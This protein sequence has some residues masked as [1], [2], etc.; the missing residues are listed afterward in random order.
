MASINK[1]ILIGNL[2][3]DPEL[4]KL[5]SGT[6][7]CTF[8]VA[9]N[10]TWKDKD[11]NKQE[12][13]EFHNIV[14]WGKLAEICGQYLHKGKQVYIEGRLETRTWEDKD[15][16]KTMYRTEIVCEEMKMLGSKSDGGGQQ[17]SGAPNGYEAP[18]KSA[19][20]SDE[21][22]IEDIPF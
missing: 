7:V 11:G 10:R 1:A 17:S 12:K 13:A 5:D 19:A 18:P 22:R 4:K 21:I 16:G 2:T 15:S 8:G 3:R 20:V 6:D 9:T 14:A